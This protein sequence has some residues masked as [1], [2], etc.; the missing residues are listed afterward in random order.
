MDCVYAR[1]PCS[2]LSRWVCSNSCP[3]SQWCYSTISSSSPPA[4]Q[5]FPRIGSFLVSWLF[6]T[7]SQS[8]GASALA[9]VLPMSIQ[10][11]FPLGW[12]GWIS[13]QSKGLSRVFSCLS[14]SVLSLLY[15]PALT[16]IH[17]Y[18]NNRSFDLMNLCWQ[19]DICFLIGCLDLP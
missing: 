9:S 13:L 6:S 16:S 8:I 15:G 7:G 2:S 4:H 1:L 11:W 5:S 18:W 17:D 12:T 3:L 19:S 10:D 14:S